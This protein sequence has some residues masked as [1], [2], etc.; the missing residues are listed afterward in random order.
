VE[1]RQRVGI[2]LLDL[3]LAALIVVI[4]SAILIPVLRARSRA[5]P[6]GD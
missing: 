1:L 2:S 5:S 6:P 3:F 4:L